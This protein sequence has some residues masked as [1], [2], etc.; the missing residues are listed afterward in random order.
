M[1]LEEAIKVLKNH[2]IWRRYN[3]ELEESPEMENPKTLG[4][5]IDVVVNNFSKKS[6]CKKQCKA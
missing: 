1:K 2:N 6:I 5:A 3:G 4:I